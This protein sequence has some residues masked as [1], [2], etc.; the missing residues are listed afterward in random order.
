[1]GAVRHVDPDQIHALEASAQLV[2]GLVGPQGEGLLLLDR[3]L[4]GALLAMLLQG[5]VGP[6]MPVRDAERGMVIYLV[7]ALLHETEAPWTVG[8]RREPPKEQSLAVDLGITL[9]GGAM[10]MATGGAMGMATGG[11]MGM[12]TLVLPRRQPTAPQRRGWSN[13]ARLGLIACHA[14]VVA[15]R[16]RLTVSEVDQL[17]AGDVILAPGIPGASDALRGW[18]CVGQ[19]N[20]E[21]MVRG[22]GLEVSGSLK[23]GGEPMDQDRTRPNPGI[24]EMAA[25]EGLPVEITVELGRVRISAAELLE[26]EVGDVLTLGRPT[27]SAVDLR[28]GDRLLARGELVDVE[29]EAGVRLIEVYA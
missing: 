14:P 10:G 20:I 4:V 27:V 26:L 13:R 28:V 12:A 22:A 19:G 9:Q 16:L 3:E 18:L 15:A 5:A 23:I 24:E 11:A 17:G 29:G 1:M 7:G 6:P 2:I 21:V 8:P 25:V